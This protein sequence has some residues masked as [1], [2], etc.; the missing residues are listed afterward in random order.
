MNKIL[1]LSCMYIGNILFS[2]IASAWIYLGLANG[3]GGI[4][5]GDGACPSDY[6]NGCLFGIAASNPSNLNASQ[7]QL[8]NSKKR[9]LGITQTVQN[10]TFVPAKK[11]I[12]SNVK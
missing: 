3:C 10:A 1:I 2:P 6:S 9:E 12:K 8:I 5:W 7:L 11:A 4:C